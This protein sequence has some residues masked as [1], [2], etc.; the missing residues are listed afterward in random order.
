MWNSL[1]TELVTVRLKL[2]CV[3]VNIVVLFT[4]CALL[5]AFTIVIPSANNNENN[6]NNNNN[7]AHLYENTQF[8]ADHILDNAKR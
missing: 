1:T 3:F 4:S 7:N 8:T 2:C 6:N 5:T